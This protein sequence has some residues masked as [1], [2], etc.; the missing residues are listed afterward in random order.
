MTNERLTEIALM[1]IH[2]E[3]ISSSDHV[4]NEFAKPGEHR[5]VFL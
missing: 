2:A 5:L 1:H 4:M 3:L